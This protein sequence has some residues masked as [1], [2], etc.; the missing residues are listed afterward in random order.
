MMSAIPLLLKTVISVMTATSSTLPSF[1]RRDASAGT[2]KD[3]LM[4]VIRT[5]GHH[6]ER[7]LSTD[8]VPKGF[9][10]VP[11]GA[12]AFP[13]LGLFHVG[14]AELRRYATR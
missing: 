10:I 12:G 13:A 14:S 9:A 6:K 11:A 5:R 1:S 2:V 3:G 7:V 4:P 8:T